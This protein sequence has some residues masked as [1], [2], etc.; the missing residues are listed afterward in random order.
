MTV[1]QAM[2]TLPRWKDA[3]RTLDYLARDLNDALPYRAARIFL[4]PIGAVSRI[5]S[6]STSH[7][8]IKPRE[9]YLNTLKKE[10][11]PHTNIDEQSFYQDTSEGWDAVLQEL[12]DTQKYVEAIDKADVLPD[13]GNFHNY[14]KRSF[15]TIP[16]SVYT[17]YQ[18][19]GI[20]KPEDR[21]DEYILVPSNMT[22]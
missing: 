9:D 16:A 13:D 1:V 15:L 18:I 10:L 5:V 7:L 17:Y 12:D 4:D 19:P 3:T 8:N 11:L 6:P 22:Y 2:S 20:A 21:S 14:S